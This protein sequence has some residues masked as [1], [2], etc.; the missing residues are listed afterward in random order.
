MTHIL[1]VS[2]DYQVWQVLS[3]IG[4]E[5]QF[6]FAEADGAL[7]AARLLLAYSA[8]SEKLGA[9]M[10][11]EGLSLP[12]GE[13]LCRTLRALCTGVPVFLLSSA[14][15]GP[16]VL[17][18][19]LDEAEAREFFIGH[20]LPTTSPKAASQAWDADY[21]GDSA[22]LFVRFSAGAD[23]KK[24]LDALGATARVEKCSLLRGDFD[25]ALL[26]S[27]S[28]KGS[29]EDRVR[30]AEGIASHALIPFEVPGL[31]EPAS[32]LLGAFE[33]IRQE[34]LDAQSTIE[35]NPLERAK[36]VQS[37]LIIEI[38]PR[39]LEA[40]FVSAYLMEGVTECFLGRGGDRIVCLLGS[41]SFSKIDRKTAQTVSGMDGVLRVHSYRLV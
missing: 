35:V 22:M 23:A 9:V 41:D 25:A 40:L 29:F 26:V 28:E 36:F 20:A 32:R 6:Q 5:S 13:K 30:Q 21:T 31:T 16:D 39:Y 38:D 19:P 37:Y 2:T 15:G 7:A 24:T 1:V 33:S 3:R 14:R 17:P 10:V 34:D 8:S 27:G 12:T 11:D 4:R 18:K